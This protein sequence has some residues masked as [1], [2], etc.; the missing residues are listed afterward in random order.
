MEA[1][2]APFVEHL[3]LKLLEGFFPSQTPFLAYSG[4]HHQTK[5]TVITMGKDKAYDTG[6]DSVGTVPSA[7]ATFL[8]LAKN[9]DA[10]DSTIDLVLNAG[11]CGGFSIKGAEIGDVFLTT[12]VAN[13]DRRIPIPGFDTYGIGKL[14]TIDP[15]Q[16]AVRL[17]V[18]FF[19]VFTDGS[20]VYILRG[21]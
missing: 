4:V 20:S 10:E 7:L 16:M 3:G 21:R 11:T 13:H 14:E 12:G 1:E 6:V 5:V 18:L 2:A 15:Q 17:W 9:D 8:A 19:G